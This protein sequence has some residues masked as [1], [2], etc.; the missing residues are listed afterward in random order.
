[1]NREVSVGFGLNRGVDC[2]STA[3][4]LVE[5]EGEDGEPSL[6]IGLPTITCEKLLLDGNCA[7]IFGY[8]CEVSENGGGTILTSD[9]S[10][11]GAAEPVA[12]G[13][14]LYPKCAFNPDR[15]R[16]VDEL[17]V[18]RR[19]L[20]DL[21]CDASPQIGDKSL[22]GHLAIRCDALKRFTDYVLRLDL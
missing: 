22:V 17:Q 6:R 12:N 7:V 13:V 8:T 18:L 9:A 5:T 4:E 19:G 20:R 15:E 10:R 2:I 14:H 21:V 11:L 16:I 3:K 1:M